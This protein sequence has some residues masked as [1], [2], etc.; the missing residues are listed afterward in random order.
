MHVTECQSIEVRNT[1]DDYVTPNVIGVS[2]DS[3]VSRGQIREIRCMTDYIS[4]YIP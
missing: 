1:D 2:D 4:D 3:G